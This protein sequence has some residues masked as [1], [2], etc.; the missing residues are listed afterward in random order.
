M[1]ALY[2]AAALVAL[3]AIFGVAC[4]TPP[5][6]WCARAGRQRGPG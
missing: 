6:L 3:L 1:R 5:L 4:K 2:A